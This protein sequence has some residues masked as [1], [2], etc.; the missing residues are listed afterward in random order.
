MAGG[1]SPAI[2]ELEEIAAF[3]QQH[4]PLLGR[5]VVLRGLADEALNGAAGTAID[6]ACTERNERGT[7]WL[8]GSERYTVKLDGKGGRLVQA[9]VQEVEEEEDDWSVGMGG[10]Q[11]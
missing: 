6:F 10:L 3:I 4:C 1:C 2:A 9:R 5:R 8:N 7:G 11:Y